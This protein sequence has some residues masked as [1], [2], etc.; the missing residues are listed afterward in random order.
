MATVAP[1][2]V[3]L[4]TYHPDD[5]LLFDYATGR[6]SEAE[7]LVI[8][9]HATLCPRCRNRIA[10]FEAVGGALV[11]DIAPV[12]M[13]DTAF[14]AVL[15]QIDAEPA[16][17]L[18]PVSTLSALEQR[19]I[20]P[21]SAVL[22][23]PILNYLDNP[24]TLTWKSVV[25]GLEEIALPIAGATVKLLRIKAG[26]AMP[27]HTHSGN[28]MT[29]VLA[30]AF[31]DETGHYRRGDVAANDHDVDHR[32]VADAGEDCICLVVTDAPLRLTGPIGRLLNPFVKF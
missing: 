8:A 23:R 2:M 30:G 27:Q 22:P 5:A 13:A 17:A 21:G 10:E 6:T 11:E 3:R 12:A 14:A 26:V 16:S 20:R 19:S 18:G 7:S 29:M 15:S 25:R 4:P 28:E 32:P 24:E 9:A 31:R 1:P